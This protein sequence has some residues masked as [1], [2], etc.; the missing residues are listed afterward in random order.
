[1]ILS[2]DFQISIEEYAQRGKENEFPVLDQCP[3]CHCAAGGNVYRHGFYWR[4]GI[5]ED[6]TLRIPICRLKCLL[7]EMSFSILPDFLLPYFQYTLHTIL[8]RIR[9]VLEN[10]KG[11]SPRQLCI[12]HVRRFLKGIPWIHSYFVD[13]RKKKRILE[14]GKKEPLNYLKRIMNVGESSFLR[15]S[16][17][18]LST[19]FMAN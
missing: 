18:H 11:N 19:Y 6:V 7:C 2:H 4:N 3:N 17:N 1:M 16:W 14:K 5:T 9:E 12:F 8:K 15:K 13:D 10:K